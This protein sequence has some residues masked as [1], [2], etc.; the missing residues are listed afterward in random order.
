MEMEGKTPSSRADKRRKGDGRATREET[1]E[2]WPG[3]DRWLHFLGSLPLARVLG[4]PR[5]S[6]Y[7]GERATARSRACERT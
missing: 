3:S 1:R 5:A 2:R 6:I 4:S 7:E